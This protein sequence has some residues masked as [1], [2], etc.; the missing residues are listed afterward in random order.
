MKKD[1]VTRYGVT[2]LSLLIS[3]LLLLPVSSTSLLAE[4]DQEANEKEN[5][6]G[7]SVRVRQRYYEGNSNYRELPGLEIADSGV[8][9]K[10]WTLREYGV[11]ENPY[12][13]IGEAV[14][15]YSF[16]TPKNWSVKNTIRR[17]A[18]GEDMLIFRITGEK[19]I[20]GIV[21]RVKL[22]GSSFDDERE[23]ARYYASRRSDFMALLEDIDDAEVTTK[24]N[25]IQGL[26]TRKSEEV[27][28][29]ESYSTV[30]FPDGKYANV[31][32][33]LLR[34]DLG[35][36]VDMYIPHESLNQRLRTVAYMIGKSFTVYRF[37]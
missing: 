23:F 5:Y 34:K 18:S 25:F 2:F 9:G 22:P 28:H 6:G 30:E 31:A 10:S 8:Y 13:I 32:Q 16:R 7:K 26:T 1:P 24:L 14:V 21:T 36:V 19:G 15:S 3:V 29:Y 4:N 11:D 35:Y 27:S 37:R 12:G 20:W 33:Y 17:F